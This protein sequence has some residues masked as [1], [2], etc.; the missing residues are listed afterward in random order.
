MKVSPARSG[1]A[2]SGPPAL[3]GERQAYTDVVPFARRVVEEFP[4]SVLWGSDWPHPNLTGHMPDDGL[5][6]DYVP[7]VAVTSEAAAQIARGQPDAALLARR[8]C[9]NLPVPFPKR[10]RP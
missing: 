5:L 10:A 4:D 6:V 3:D 7:R 1:S 9:L 2:S 8:R